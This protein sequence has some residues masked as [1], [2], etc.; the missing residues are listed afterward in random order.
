MT[1]AVQRA[2]RGR[3]PSA[4]MGAEEV[5]RL[6]DLFEGAG[7]E[8]WIDGGWGVDALLESELREHDDLDLVAH[9]GDS[10][11]IVRVLEDAGY[12]VVA[13]A[14][15]KSFVAVTADGRQVDVHPVT[16]DEARGGGVY[17]MDDGREWVY[18][19]AGFSGTGRVGGRAVRCLTP[20]VQVLVHEG[21]ELEEKDYRE[22]R[23]L[24]ERFGVELPRDYDRPA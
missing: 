21:Y 20:E 19:A 2:Y 3:V 9:L 7:V 10:Q 6:L 15:P 23:L 8:V 13:G 1:E 16:F 4:R 18:P 5:V 24:H 22:L 11:T 17:L 12:E 14:A